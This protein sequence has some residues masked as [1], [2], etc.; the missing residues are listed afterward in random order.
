MQSRYGANIQ[1]DEGTETLERWGLSS[2]GYYLY[3]GRFVPENAI[4]LLI[5]AFRR[6]RTERRLVIVG[7]APYMDAYKAE[8]TR[9]AEGDPRIVFTGYAFG[10][11]Y[12]QLS[13][14]AYAYVQPSGI[15]GTRPAL[16]DQMG[17]GNAVL[18]RDSKV[19]MEVIEEG[20][21]HFDRHH[22]EDSLVRALEDLD[23]APERVEALRRGVRR[24]IEQFYNWDWIASFYEDLF[25]RMKQGRDLVSYDRFLREQG[26]PVDGP[27]A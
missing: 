26:P 10:E 21:A 23:A 6:M 13:S 24:R 27:G 17:F 8:L 2:R 22:P 20:G 15:D 3:V 18:V 4:D 16:L 7:D 25:A 14:H 11:A 1:R 12:A 19:N 9:L 5:R